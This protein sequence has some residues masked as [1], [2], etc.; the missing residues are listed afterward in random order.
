MRRTPLRRYKGFGRPKFGNVET[1]VLGILFR[2]KLEANHALYLESERQKGRIKGWRYEVPIALHAKGG[3]KVGDYIVDFE[4]DMGDYKEWH[5]VKGMWTDL[6]RWK[7]KHCRLEYNR[8]VRI[9][10]N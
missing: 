4:V 5:E 3:G 1:K 2:S 6:A 10:K 8:I 7:V 9:I